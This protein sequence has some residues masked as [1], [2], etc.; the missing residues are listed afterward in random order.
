MKEASKNTWDL[1]VRSLDEMGLFNFQ[2]VSFS[3][4]GSLSSYCFL[5]LP[6]PCPA[7]SLYRLPL[8]L[9]PYHTST[10][11][12]NLGFSRYDDKAKHSKFE[13]I[14]LMTM[15]SSVHG[16]ISYRLCHRTYLECVLKVKVG[17]RR[18]HERRTASSQRQ[19]VDTY[20]DEVT[21]PLTVIH[22]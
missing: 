11:L 22:V 19:H 14:V 15:I 16:W 10:C 6:L 9:I 18:G 13:L 17:D 1:G 5:L 3:F 21:G 12:T 2:T 4:P 7:V 8:R 20:H